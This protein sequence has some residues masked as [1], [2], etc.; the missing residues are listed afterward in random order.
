MISVYTPD[1]WVVVKIESPQ[2]TYY[3][4]M[5]CWY[6]G[7]AGSNSWKMNSGIAKFE[8]HENYI[9]FI[10][11]SGSVYR[12][13]KGQGCERLNMYAYSVLQG[14]IEDGSKAEPPIKLAEISFEEFKAEFTPPNW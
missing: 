4:I 13:G 11:A 3:R 5:A 6:G 7:F 12:C 9:D 8:E 1:G 2:E 10:G 14:F